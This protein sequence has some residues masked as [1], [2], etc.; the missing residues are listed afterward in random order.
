[1]TKTEKIEVINKT[2]K[3]DIPEWTSYSS[4]EIDRLYRSVQQGKKVV[5]LGYEYVVEAK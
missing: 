5:K 3:V 4:K 2:C 1:M